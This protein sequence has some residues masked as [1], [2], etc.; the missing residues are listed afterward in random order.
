MRSFIVLLFFLLSVS[1]QANNVQLTNIA[2]TNNVNNTGKIIS[3]DLSWEN[4]WRV[5]STGNLDG[6]WVFFKFRDNNGQWYHLNFT[7]TNIIMPSGASYDLGNNG[8]NTGI[9]MFIYRSANGTGSVNFTNIRAGITSYPG[10]FEV[11]G[12]AIEMV[13]IPQGSFFAGDG[14]N[15]SGYSTAITGTPYNVTGTSLTFG[16]A[17]GN[18]NDPNAGGFSGTLNNF[19][20][21]YNAFWMMKYEVS[22]GAYRD[23]LNTLTKQQQITRFQVSPESTALYMPVQGN[24]SYLY[25]SE[26]RINTAAGVFTP[27]VV[28]CGTNDT[29]SNEWKPIVFINWM[30][31]AAY[32]DWAG[33]RPLTELEYEKACR[34]PLNAVPGEFAWGTT[35]ITAWP[36]LGINSAYGNIVPFIND[37]E[38]N[39]TVANASAVT[40][41][42]T[43]GSERYSSGLIP[44]WI[45]LTRGGVFATAISTRVSAG[46]GYFG[47][48]ELSG[49]ALEPV[50]TTANAA[51]RAY[52]GKHGDGVL[53]PQGNADENNWPGVNGAT[54]ITV[55]PGTYNGGNGVSSDGGITF[56]GG[57]H[58]SPD[59]NALR[60]SVR[61]AVGAG[62]S[63]S[64]TTLLKEELGIRGGR[65]LN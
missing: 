53:T 29:A 9:G 39:E 50:V 41:N 10:I 46:A 8:G 62:A 64:K 1:V 48:M 59:S 27:A 24:V 45:N 32:L 7:G 4:S 16:T 54:G 34:G 5:S 40:G 58:L 13:F 30:D 23:F 38:I 43:Y 47:A 60:V 42:A 57:S 18:L 52:T 19:P 36:G 21:G 37:G 28:R 56:R 12:F 20:T 63:T 6:V 33:L 15:S 49:N 25:E 11:R 17:A 31:A 44:Y 14:Q 26:L 2:V 61:G 3:F 35:Q 51:G 65:D 55:A 22:Q